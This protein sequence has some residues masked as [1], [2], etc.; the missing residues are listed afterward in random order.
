MSAANTD[1][2]RRPRLGMRD[3]MRMEVRR[4]ATV[5]SSYLIVTV[6]FLLGG[7]IALMIGLLAPDDTALSPAR[8]AAA[9]TSGADA[10]P[11]SVTGGLLA[12]LGV[13]A[14]GHDYRFGLLRTVLIVQPRR[15]V[16]VAARL[17]VLAGIAGVV[18]FGMSV[19]AAGVCSLVGRTPSLDST[20]LRVAG[21]H[22]ILAVLWAWLGAGLAWALRSSSAAISVLLIGPLFVEPVLMVAAQVDGSGSLRAVFKWLP[23]AA[24]RQALG[25][26][27]YGT[28]EMIG[29]L[30]GG[31]VFAGTTILILGFGWF[32]LQRRDV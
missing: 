6:A 10:V 20:T 24:A 32:L 2:P 23:F 13:L 12:L 17:V 7:V 30:V 15:S 25:Q 11:M 31:I 8:T 29:A 5:R 19:V 9:L 14:V 21:A 18:A 26:Q 3:T 4:L 1:E 27:L 16:V 28:G 22:V